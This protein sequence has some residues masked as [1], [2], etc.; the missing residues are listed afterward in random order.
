MLFLIFSYEEAPS[1]KGTGTHF[2][3]APQFLK[4]G[5]VLVVQAERQ[6]EANFIAHRA[7]KFY[8]FPENYR[9]IM[10]IPLGLAAG[11]DVRCSIF[12]QTAS[13]KIAFRGICNASKAGEEP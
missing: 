12:G 8:G 4:D 7:L 2:C 1:E 9:K 5:T 6:A 13:G 3:V 11:M 10:S